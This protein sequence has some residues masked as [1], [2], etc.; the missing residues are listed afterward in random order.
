[1]TDPVERVREE[2][3]EPPVGA[4][5]GTADALPA[6]DDPPPPPRLKKPYRAWYKRLG[7]YLAT[8]GRG[9]WR[10]GA[11]DEIFFL[12]G[13][14]SFNVLV[15]FIPLVITVIGIA[16][17]VL[18]FQGANAEQTLLNYLANVIPA[19]V[20]LDIAGILENLAA[21]STGILS[22][23]TLF[24][25]WVATRLVG[26]LRVVLRDIFDI[27]EGRGIVAGKIFD[28][29]M[30]IAAGTLFALNVALTLGLRLS[31]DFGARVLHIDPDEIP[32]ISEASRLWPQLV[33]FITIWVMFLLIYRYLPPRRIKWSTAL[34][35]ATFTAIIGEA[36]KFGFG[37]Y[38]TGVADFRTTWGNIATF[39]ILVIWVYYTAVV[40]VLGGEVAQVI[41]I[42]RTRK[43]Q[44]ERLA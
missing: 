44:K 28:I 13:A 29:K 35:A 11:E 9:V 18:R 17:L 12:A 34:T 8:L 24:F 15:A 3:D 22:I 31:A 7:S 36:L 25:L 40:F 33:A 26:T 19:A 5:P 21:Q 42:Q 4:E 14:I 10:K 27:P 32:F 30:L 43:R 23:G 2:E 1:M 39:V 37:Y 16:G 6:H 38:V 41:S 20:T